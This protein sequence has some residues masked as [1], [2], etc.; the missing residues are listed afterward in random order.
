MFDVYYQTI[1]AG[2][3]FVKHLG[4]RSCLYNNYRFSRAVALA[5]AW[6]V[7]TASV[8]SFAHCPSSEARTALV[9]LH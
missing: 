5:E 1:P 3:D 8:S 4:S 6:T 2:I 7:S 9:E